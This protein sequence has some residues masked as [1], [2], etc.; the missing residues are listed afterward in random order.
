[1]G[2][3][4]EISKSLDA[5]HH[6]VCKFDS[7]QDPDYIS[8]RNALRTLINKFCPTSKYIPRC[9]ASQSDET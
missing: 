9:L 3:P 2:Y 5:D 7:N 6:T 8:V 4:N 1:M